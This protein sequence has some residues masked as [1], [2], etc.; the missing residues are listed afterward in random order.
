M[1]YVYTRCKD[2]HMYIAIAI[3]RVVSYQKCT[4]NSYIKIT[5]FSIVIKVHLRIFWLGNHA[6]DTITMERGLPFSAQSN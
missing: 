1:H 5:S 3:F 4:A 2:K 6:D